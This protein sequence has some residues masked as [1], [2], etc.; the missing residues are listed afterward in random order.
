MCDFLIYDTVSSICRNNYDNQSEGNKLS[1][2]SYDQT[3]RCI[4]SS[5]LRCWG[6]RDTFW[7]SRRGSN[8]GDFFGL[9]SSGRHGNSF[10]EDLCGHNGNVTNHVV[11]LCCNKTVT[12]SGTADLQLMTKRECHAFNKSEGRGCRT[13]RDNSSVSFSNGGACCVKSV[14]SRGYSVWDD[15]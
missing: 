13:R 2:R 7:R 4:G 10:P 3:G 11:H 5:S 1:W 12:G 9:E 6:V 8:Y 14:A 15:K